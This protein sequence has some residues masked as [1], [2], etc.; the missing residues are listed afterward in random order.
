MRV[1]LEQVDT[2]DLDD[3]RKQVVALSNKDKIIEADVNENKS[4]VYRFGTVAVRWSYLSEKWL[5]QDGVA[6]EGT[7]PTAKE[8][9]QRA[10]EISGYEEENKSYII[11]TE[12]V[13]ME[14]DGTIPL[15]IIQSFQPTPVSAPP[16][17]GG[18]GGGMAS[19]NIP[20]VGDTGGLPTPPPGGPSTGGGM[21]VGLPEPSGGPGSSSG[22]PSPTDLGL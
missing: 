14:F 19:L 6:I 12:P 1:L 17:S 4:R 9:V 7:Y 10:K 2:I 22:A 8:A 3:L 16:P 15:D 20:S 13:P 21:D 11:H 18:G 5:L